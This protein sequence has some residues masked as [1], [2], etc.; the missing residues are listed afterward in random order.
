MVVRREHIGLDVAD[1]C[2]GIDEER[3]ILRLRIAIAELEP[4]EINLA[5]IKQR[6][7]RAVVVRPQVEARA[8]GRGAVAVFGGEVEIA[9]IAHRQPDVGAKGDQLTVARAALA[10]RVRREQAR[11]GG[12]E[13]RLSARGLQAGDVGDAGK[14]GLVAAIARRRTSA[15]RCLFQL[16][17]DDAGDRVRAVLRRRTVAQHFDALDRERRDGVQVDCRRAAPDGAVDVEQRRDVA[18]LA[19]DEHEHLIGR[20]AAQRRG[21]QRV[22]AV[23]DRRLREVEAGDQV[24]EDLVRLGQ[25]RL[26]QL[27]A[28][29]DVDRHVRIGERPVGPARAGDDDLRF[30]LDRH[31]GSGRGRHLCQRGRAGQRS[32]RKRSEHQR[33]DRN[34]VIPRRIL[35]PDSRER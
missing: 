16:D 2:R 1:R 26:R 25:P 5:R 12:V 27:L 8:V 6:C 9:A 35:R 10:V 34:H 7:C 23:G 22:G 32:H 24:V 31:V 13:E 4:V 28:R 3:E 33:A 18:A 19:V 14:L 20:K 30:G 15:R 17:V 21:P 29:N 11:V